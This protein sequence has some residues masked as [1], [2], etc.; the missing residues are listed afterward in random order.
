M[1]EP[2]KPFI[3]SITIDGCVLPD[4][5]AAIAN[6][7]GQQVGQTMAQMPEPIATQLRAHGVVVHVFTGTEGMQ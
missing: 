1:S 5:T 3:A 7:I 6:L 2:V 4:S